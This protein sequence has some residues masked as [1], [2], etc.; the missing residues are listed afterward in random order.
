MYLA[1]DLLNANPGL[2]VWIA[3]VFTGFVLLLRKFAWGP[4]VSA[5]EEREQT[6]A[7]SIN[8]AEAALAESKRLQESNTQA[9]RKAEQ[10]AQRLVRKAREEAEALRAQE[11]QRTREEINA[12]R[13]QAREEIARDKDSA[14][15]QLRGEV[16]D[17]AILAA[18]RILMESLN[19]KR[20]HT[21]V[22]RFIDD[23]SS[24]KGDAPPYEA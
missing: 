9:R 2:I 20:H 17:L 1:A 22:D 5:L 3:V 21:L 14:L 4:I 13:A 16:A 12:L 11:V 18:E 8:R 10:E 6:I 7:N 19:A 23:L 24:R 15:Q